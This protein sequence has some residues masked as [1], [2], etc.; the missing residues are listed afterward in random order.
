MAA[1][2]KRPGATAKRER[3]ARLKQ[4]EEMKRYRDK[5]IV[6]FPK[7]RYQYDGYI[8]KKVAVGLPSGER[9]VISC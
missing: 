8:G 9:E 5:V 4:R 1:Q 3:I 2:H 7:G 6:L